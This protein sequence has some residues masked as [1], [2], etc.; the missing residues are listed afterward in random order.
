M[1]SRASG[2]PST[3]SIQALG[4]RMPEGAVSVEARDSTGTDLP[5]AVA[6]GVWLVLPPFH[7]DLDPMV[8]FFTADGGLMR[9][10][11]PEHV[12]TDPL[13]DVEEPCP[14]CGASQ[15]RLATVPEH[16]NGDTESIDSDEWRPGRR[17][18]LCDRCGFTQDLPQIQYV[19]H[20]LR[21]AEI[22]RR[23]PLADRRAHSLEAR[24]Y[25]ARRTRPD[26]P[27][28]DLAGIPQ[29]QRLGRS[30]R[31]RRLNHARPWP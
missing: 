30:G 22:G 13:A 3:G 19:L 14:S 10:L 26:W 2:C 24:G 28:T 16:A 25:R 21:N 7:S 12:L 31:V 9:R 29:H 1:R 23:P 6:Q 20:R 17:A 11:L 18:A 8:R 15:W 5:V 4:G 27:C